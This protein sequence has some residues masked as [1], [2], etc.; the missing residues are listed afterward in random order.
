M[1]AVDDDSLSKMLDLLLYGFI[2]STVL[3]GI[4]VEY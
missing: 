1:Q 4:I 2:D 3:H